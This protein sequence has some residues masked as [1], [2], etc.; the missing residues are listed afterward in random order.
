MVVIDL[1]ELLED[2]KL[3][4]VP[5]AGPAGLPAWPA[6]DRMWERIM[7]M[8]TRA[9]HSVLVLCPIP[10]VSE[11][12][13]PADRVSRWILLDCPDDSR[14]SRLRARGWDAESIEDAI[15]DARLGRE[16]VR[17][18]VCWAGESPE[19]LSQRV[20]GL[21]KVRRMRDSN[22]RER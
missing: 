12:R 20:D 16:M 2:G 15:A 10:S 19:E 4:D 8:I 6:Y 9:G 3:L 11:L 14:R 7:S 21:V 18:V 1:D 13:E 17:D 22:P 5:I